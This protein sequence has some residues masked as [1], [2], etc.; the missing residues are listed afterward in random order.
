M[1]KSQFEMDARL[2]GVLVARCHENAWP[3]HVWVGIPR[4]SENGNRVVRVSMEC[5][6]GF[7][8]DEKLCGVV[9]EFIVICG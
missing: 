3:V 7:P 6:D 5:A 2:A 8:L 4:L 9:Q 1:K